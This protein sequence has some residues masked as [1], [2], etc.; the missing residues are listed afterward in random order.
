M[1]CV[2]RV[3]SSRA[4][5]R[6]I[7]RPPMSSGLTTMKRLSGGFDRSTR[8]PVASRH[9]IIDDKQATSGSRARGGGSM[10]IQLKNG[11]PEWAASACR[12]AGRETL[13]TTW[14]P[15]W[16]G[17]RSRSIEGLGCEEV[18]DGAIKG[19]VLLPGELT[20]LLLL[21]RLGSGCEVRNRRRATRLS[22]PLGTRA[23]SSEEGG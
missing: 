22:R 21:V 4:R 15:A 10:G 5:N 13:K 17:W 7:S 11:R 8:R 2:G 12:S 20:P 16:L 19:V 14:P 3:R 9:Q 23:A 6:S 18:G 1:Q